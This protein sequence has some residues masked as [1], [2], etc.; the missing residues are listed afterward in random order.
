MTKK[1]LL[2]DVVVEFSIDDMEEVEA[3]RR[4]LQRDLEELERLLNDCV[5]YKPVP[6]LLPN[7]I[8]AAHF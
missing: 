6:M 7:H 4:G 3:M 8:Y 5:V 1:L 2:H